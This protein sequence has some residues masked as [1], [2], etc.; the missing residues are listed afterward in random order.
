MTESELKRCADTLRVFVP[1]GQLTELRAFH[2]SN[3]GPSYVGF[4]DHDHLDD[5]AK[6]ADE[7]SRVCR[8]VYFVPNP[9]D[10]AVLTKFGDPNVV[11]ENVRGATDED[12]AARKWLLIDVDPERPDGKRSDSATDAERREAWKVVSNVREGLAAFGMTAPVLASSGNG[13]HLVY[14]I[15]MPNDAQSRDA[16]QAVLRGLA[17]RFDTAKAKVDVKNFNASRI[18]KLY[19]TTARKGRETPERPHRESFVAEKPTATAAKTARKGNTDGM[20]QFVVNAKRQE[21]DFDR[22]EQKAISPEIVRR[23]KSF[24]LKSGPAVAGQGGHT[25]TFHLTAAL[26]EGFGLDESDALEAL[27]EWNE[28][29]QPPW[30]EKELRHKVKDAVRKFGSSPQRGYM[31]GSTVPLAQIDGYTG[32][33]ESVTPTSEMDRDAT[34]ADLIALGKRIEWVWPFWIQKSTL[35]C[36]ASDPGVG[37]TRL[38]WDLIRRVKLQMPWPDGAEMTLP[39]DSRFLYVP[40]D[41]NHAQLGAIAEQ[42]GIDPASVV[43][44][45]RLGNPYVGTMLDTKDDL[46]DFEKR[47]E[48]VKPSIVFVDTSWNATD[49]DTARTSEAKKFFK[50]LGDI[51]IR[52]ATSIVML[53]H[54]S[55]SGHALG[56]RIEGIARQLIMITRPDPEKPDRRRL[57]VKKS[58]STEPPALGV[59][60]LPNGMDFDNDPPF[61]PGKSQP[62]NPED[63]KWLTEQLK[64]GPRRVSYLRSLAEEFNISPPRLYKS[65]DR[66]RVEEFEDT[67]GGNRLFKFWRLPPGQDDGDGRE[68]PPTD[69]GGDT[70]T[71]E[72]L[73]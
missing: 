6:S 52:H 67:Q 7:L 22:H 18:W 26:V 46:S 56:R 4:F 63:D 69:T 30:S 15:D 41:N 51:A 72:E 50:P 13:W 66:L 32:P 29:C 35:T 33:V 62:A 12:I 27:K 31:L 40:A 64:D 38:C 17:S 70:D 55:A 23:A 28:T 3:D 8:G 37:K 60:M 39:A 42:F 54:L 16:I 48:R 58:D 57:W 68:A 11:R 24:L 25:H 73:F 10:F 71:G 45:T 65:R 53:T 21:E 19:G 5:M 44:N 47:I 61:E 36:L 9:I 43:L 1:K 14:P 34:V 20:S 2:K 59:T 49:M